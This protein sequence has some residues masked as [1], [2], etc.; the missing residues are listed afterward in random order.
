M[1]RFLGDQDLLIVRCNRSAPDFGS[2]LICTP[3]D[4]RQDWSVVADSFTGFVAHFAKEQ[5]AKFW[6]TLG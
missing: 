2:V 5:G 6:E 3:L 4:D 1:G